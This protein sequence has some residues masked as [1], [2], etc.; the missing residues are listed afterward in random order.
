LT[1]QKKDLSEIVE[2]EAEDDNTFD[3]IAKITN[4]LNKLQINYDDF[5]C[6]FE[7]DDKYDE[8]FDEEGM[9]IQPLPI[10]REE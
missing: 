9:L 3:K 10:S 6:Q 4:D 7:L 2:L 8:Y 1:R 5:K